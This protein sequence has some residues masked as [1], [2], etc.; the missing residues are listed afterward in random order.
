M[1]RV[2]KCSSNQKLSSLL[3]VPHH[4]F[5]RSFT[6]DN[7][8]QDVDFKLEP[9]SEEDN[10]DNNAYQELVH[11]MHLFPGAGHQV[12]IIQPFVKWGPKKNELTTADLMLDEAQALVDSLPNWKC[13]VHFISKK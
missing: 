8:P 6:G 3:K 5:V 9:S 13:I 7:K 2:V 10:Q 1:I 4:T 12:V 11:R